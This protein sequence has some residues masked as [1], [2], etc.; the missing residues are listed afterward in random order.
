MAYKP[1]AAAPARNSRRPVALPCAQQEVSF[2]RAILKGR[3]T[4]SIRTEALRYESAVKSPRLYDARPAACKAPSPQDREDLHAVVVAIRDE[5]VPV[6]QAELSRIVEQAVRA[7]VAERA[8]EQA[9]VLV[10]QHDG[11][12]VTVDH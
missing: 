8:R 12:R 3:M 11:L 1:A 9:A 4:T 10:E 7:S 5:R 2:E 6:R